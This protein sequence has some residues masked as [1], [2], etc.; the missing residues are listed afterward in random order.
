MNGMRR[1]S[2]LTLLVAVV[3]ACYWLLGDAPPTP[4]VDRGAPIAVADDSP[5]DV[6]DATAAAPTRT[7]MLVPAPARPVA[8]PSTT[9][10]H[11]DAGDIAPRDGVRVS[12]HVVDA[13]GQ[14]FADAR[15][16]LSR[17]GQS[18]DAEER[19]A[20]TEVSQRTLRNGSYA[21]K[22][23]LEPGEW[24]LRVSHEGRTCE[25]LRPGSSIVLA[26]A[27]QVVD[28]VVAAIPARAVVEGIVVDTIGAPIRGARVRAWLPP[29][30]PARTTSGRDGTFRLIQPDAF[31]SDEPFSF[32]V[33]AEG[34]EPLETDAEHRFGTTGVR[35]VVDSGPILEVR[36]RRADDGT[37]VENF[38][39]RIVP[40]PGGAVGHR[41][42]DGTPRGGTSHPRGVARIPLRETGP[43][44]VSVEPESSTGL[45]G[46]AFVEVDVQ[47]DVPAIAEV[48]LHP[49]AS[50]RVVV[51]RSNG[52]P[53]VGAA[54][55]LLVP[56]NA[57]PITNSTAVLS[58]SDWMNTNAPRALRVMSAPT[59]AGGECDLV[60]DPWTRHTV[61]VTGAGV[62][63]TFVADVQLADPSPL[64]IVVT[65][66]ARLTGRLSPAE[67][68]AQFEIPPFR[69]GGER[70][71]ASV[72][73][74][75]GTG[76]A[77]ERYPHNLLPGGAPVATD[78][79]FAIDGIPPGIWD[80]VLM[81]PRSRSPGHPVRSYYHVSCTLRRGVTLTSDVTTDL[82]LD[83]A[84]LRFARLRGTV[85]LDGAVGVG[86][87]WLNRTE[88]A[89]SVSATTD[90]SG[91]FEVML[92][93]GEWRMSLHPGDPPIARGFDADQR[94]VLAA[95][96]TLDATFVTRSAHARVRVVAPDG[97]PAANIPLAFHSGGEF[98][99]PHHAVTDATGHVDLRLTPG[100]YE[101]RAWLR[102]LATESAR[103]AFAR[104]NREREGGAT[105]SG[106]VVVGAVP[107]PSTDVVDLRLPP[108]WDW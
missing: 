20:T 3:A 23:P 83:V 107:I 45:C 74:E 69:P 59:S 37:P 106:I 95:G 54:V 15:V 71:A 19:E 36:V 17:R 72:V 31:P 80:I 99:V 75:R 61:R 62:Q 70:I 57:T 97:T 44:L 50:R 10:A 102:S 92:D 101:V 8:R 78:G 33:D 60:G 6:T 49:P 2:L 22:A 64:R 76:E 4:I 56:P 85:T 104:R 67:V 12:G 90:A 7:P 91:R 63:S 25:L 40:K 1:A 65:G 103:I 87:V 29:H 96:Q 21:F 73:L 51:V 5:S 42:Q 79:T 26:G 108:E 86:A 16:T 18:T 41:V 88:P 105:A 68:L 53:V 84:P 46:V 52:A 32:R 82:D 35:L 30:A 14:P 98:S 24:S 28:I 47:D 89:P 77:K 58:S 66:A 100:T 93:P 34:F 11:R 43:H 38:H 81:T 94:V 39:V 9:S 48:R 27:D 55:D 13:D